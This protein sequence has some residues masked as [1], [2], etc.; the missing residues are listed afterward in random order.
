MEFQNYIPDL[1]SLRSYQLDL[2]LFQA[3]SQE[4]HSSRNIINSGL[5]DI[6]HATTTHQ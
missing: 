3:A 2:T 4:P 5:K 1:D 6:Y